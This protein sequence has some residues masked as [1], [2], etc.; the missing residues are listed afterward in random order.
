[1]P[2][3]PDHFRWQLSEGA[4]TVSIVKHRVGAV[5][6]LGV[7]PCAVELR[8]TKEPRAGL[9][10]GLASPWLPEPA[11]EPPAAAQPPMP[12]APQPTAGRPRRRTRSTHAPPSLVGS[13]R[14]SCQERSLRRRGAPDG[15]G[16][17]AGGTPRIFVRTTTGSGR[18]SRPLPSPRRRR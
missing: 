11:P 13:R 7:I 6:A 15:A 18:Q 1:M 14:P 5:A 8:C 10:A 16:Q 12:E 17:G 4:A 3:K 2:K 9:N